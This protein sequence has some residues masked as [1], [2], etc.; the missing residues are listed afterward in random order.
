MAYSTYG[1]DISE[2]PVEIVMK[3]LAKVYAYL[4]AH[5][6]QWI[7]LDRISEV[8]QTPFQAINFA[9]ERLKMLPRI[10]TRYT[11]SRQ[12][13]FVRRIAKVGEIIKQIEGEREGKTDEEYKE[14]LIVLRK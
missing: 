9:Y 7:S 14:K 2:I 3:T 4:R 13:R 5:P 10:E 11:S 6:N 12:I 8:V 1:S